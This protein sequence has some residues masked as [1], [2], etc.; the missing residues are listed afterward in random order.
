MKIST[1]WV[2]AGFAWKEEFR[3]KEIQF[4]WGAK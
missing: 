2:W 4:I 3:V 1:P